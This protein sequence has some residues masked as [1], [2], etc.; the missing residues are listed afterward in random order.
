MSVEGLREGDVVRHK[1]GGRLM[2][3]V[4]TKAGPNGEGVRC[5]W[6]GTSGNLQSG[7]FLPA[8]LAPDGE[9]PPMGQ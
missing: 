3:V 9:T 8:D 4:A 5:E 2:T 1:T 6:F 7:L